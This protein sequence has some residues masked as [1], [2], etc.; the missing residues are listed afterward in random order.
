MKIEK[1]IREESAAKIA[2][3]K[4]QIEQLKKENRDLKGY[5]KAI[6]AQKVKLEE[7]RDTEN[8]AFNE[9]TLKM[10]EPGAPPEMKEEE[11][12]SPSVRIKPKC[13]CCIVKRIFKMA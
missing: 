8:K 2:A 7:E 6:M 4:A 13:G 11:L 1:K 5:A 3:L 10:L 12:S 9:G